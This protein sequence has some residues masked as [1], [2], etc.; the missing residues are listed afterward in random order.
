MHLVNAHGRVQRIGGLALCRRYN[1]RWQG[2]NHAGGGGPQFGLPRIRISAGGQQLAI[3]CPNL[4]LV[5]RALCHLRH[6]QLPHAALDT[7]AHGVLMTIPV[8]EVAHHTHA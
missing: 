4:I 5:Q 2:G 1:H 7:Q 3:A 8:V 6:K